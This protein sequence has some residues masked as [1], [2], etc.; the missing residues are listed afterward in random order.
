MPRGARSHV[1]VLTFR[2][3]QTV[4]PRIQEQ[5][6]VQAVTQDDLYVPITASQR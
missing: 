4:P 5:N 2:A 6:I 3:L 1:F